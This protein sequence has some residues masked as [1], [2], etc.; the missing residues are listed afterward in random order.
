MTAFKIILL[1]NTFGW[2][3]TIPT[4]PPTS[5]CSESRCQNNGT[6]IVNEDS[7]T[8]CECA[9]GF[10]GPSCTFEI[11]TSGRCR[12]GATCRKM[13]GVETCSCRD[14]YSGEFCEIKIDECLSNPCLNGG[15]CIDEVDRYLCQCLDGFGGKRCEEYCVGNFVCQNFGSCQYD[16]KSSSLYCNCLPGYVGDRCEIAPDVCAPGHHLCPE[17]ACVPLFNLYYCNCPVNGLDS[18]FCGA[19]IISTEI[20]KDFLPTDK[21]SATGLEFSWWFIAIGVGTILPIVFIS[22]VVYTRCSQK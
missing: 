5:A 14:G 19:V 15:E 10:A 16:N 2:V 11:C 8:S 4:G 13:D 12:N 7:T 9:R 20:T 17:N 18:D 3:S 21:P 1:L 6:C 22:I